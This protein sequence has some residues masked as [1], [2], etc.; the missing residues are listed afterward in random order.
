ARDRMT[1]AVW[2]RGAGLTQAC[3]SGSVA[4]AAAAWSIGV[5]DGSVVVENPGG[6]VRVELSGD[7]PENP[8]VALAGP[9]RRIGAITVDSSDFGEASS[10]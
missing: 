8:T 3:G 7:D 1:L 4:A 2:E 10:P 9:A 6:N 5:V